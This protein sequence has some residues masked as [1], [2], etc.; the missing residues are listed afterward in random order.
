MKKLFVIILL[1]TTSL[2]TM[3]AQQAGDLD[4]S[5]GEGG[6]AITDLGDGYDQCS[7]LVIQ[8]DQKIVVGGR[9]QVEGGFYPT[10]IR[11]NPDGTLDNSFD[12][13]GIAIGD[14]QHSTTLYAEADALAIQPDGKLLYAFH[15]DFFGG[16]GVAVTRFNTDGSIDTDFGINGTATEVVFEESNYTN[17]ILLQS[18]GKILVLGRGQAFDSA[19]FSMIAVRFTNDGSLDETFANDGV[20]T[21]TQSNG[22]QIIDAKQD[23]NGR[24]VLACS[25]ANTGYYDN[26]IVRLNEDGTFD[27]SFDEDGIANFNISGLYDAPQFLTLRDDDSMI[28]VGYTYSEDGTNTDWALVSLTSTGEF[29]ST[30]GSNGVVVAAFGDDNDVA[31]AVTIAPDGKILVAG[32]ITDFNIYGAI[33]R[34]NSNGELDN[35]FGT[36]GVT[37]I[38]AYSCNLENIKL[39]EDGKVVVCGWTGYSDSNEHHFTAIRLLYEGVNSVLNSVQEQNQLMIFP[40]PANESTTIKW[41][42]E[43]GCENQLLTLTDVSGRIIFQEMAGRQQTTIDTSEMSD[44]LYFVSLQNDSTVLSTSFMVTQG[45]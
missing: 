23:S 2:I 29:D 44:G 32:Y 8:P 42:M 26:V 25:T 21:F 24:I 16:G 19:P 35:S 37:L 36:N 12:S 30:F 1:S 13:D 4:I 39:Q 28:I 43:Q 18:D 11:M 41:K 7:G 9:A 22:S 17:S 20:F 10:L 45:Y 15:I 3:R 34:Y 33:V 27:N 6:I 38:D 31:E 5:F 40:N 14:I